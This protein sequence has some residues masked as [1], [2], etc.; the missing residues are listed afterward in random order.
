MM[1]SGLLPDMSRKV[2]PPEP[3]WDL[4]QELILLGSFWAGG[5]E[6]PGSHLA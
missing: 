5:V 6:R 1:G 3:S 4:H 2:F